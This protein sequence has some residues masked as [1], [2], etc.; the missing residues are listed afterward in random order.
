[1]YIHPTGIQRGGRPDSTRLETHKKPTKPRL[2]NRR[3]LP[4]YHEYTDWSSPPSSPDSSPG[5]RKVSKMLVASRT[6]D[7]YRA[8]HQQCE[9]AGGELKTL[10]KVFNARTSNHLALPAET[11]RWRPGVA[12]ACRLTAPLSPSVELSLSRPI[13]SSLVLPMG[14]P[15]K[16][17][18]MHRNSTCE[19]PPIRRW[20][21]PRNAP[22][23]NMPVQLHLTPEQLTRLLLRVFA[24][25]SPLAC[26]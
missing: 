4:H 17:E 2:L 11:G 18:L 6:R 19:V 1:M 21:L 26:V 3:V 8:I 23:F 24:P 5:K 15:A 10:R 22:I 25:G 12:Y 7:Y 16:K 13:A 14:A 9:H 20:P